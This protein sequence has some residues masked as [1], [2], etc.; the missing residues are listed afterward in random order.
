MKLNSAAKKE[1][2]VGKIAAC[3]GEYQVP[4]GTT[5]VK[6]DPRYY[7]PTE[8]ELLI[9]DATK[10]RTKLDWEPKYS[11]EDLVKEMVAS[12]VESF[13]KELLLK[14]SGFAIKNQYE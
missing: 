3:N 5:V 13:R 4:V 1:D 14:E 8:V 10:A 11:L 7:R 6:V 2:E 9:G 12:D